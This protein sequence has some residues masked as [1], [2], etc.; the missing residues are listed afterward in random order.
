MTKAA[1]LDAAPGTLAIED[2]RVA[3]PGPN[4]VLVRTV[5]AGLC[6]SD[7]H[8]MQ[9]LYPYPLPAVL[10]HES[11]GVVEAVGTQVSDFRPGDHVV[12]CVS[13]FCGSCRYCLTGRPFLCDKVGLTR[14][15]GD[16]P[17]LARNGKPLFQ[18]FDL[19][20]FSELLLVHEHL[21]VKIRPDMPLDKAALIGC[22]VQTGVGAVINTA[23]VRPGDSVAVIGCGGIGLN[24]V[25]AAAIAGASR[26]IAVDRLA[27]KLVLAEAFGA[28]DTV[29]AS[30][31]DPVAAVQ[32]LTSGGV[33]HSFEAI[34]LKATAEQAFSMLGKGGTATVIGMVPMGQRL[35]ID[36]TALISGKRLQ[37]SN[38]GSNRFRVDMPQYVDW[39]LAGRLK[40]DELVSATMPL[41][42]INDGFATLQGGHVARQLILF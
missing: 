3:D 28:T 40:L 33:D 16:P 10:G 20:S 5:A 36:A 12:S 15:P 32:E 39:Y 8:F 27:E 30:A 35:E 19:A 6:H 11:S 38:M 1:V 13:G 2:I 31:T 14:G 37:G 26:I 29:D 4:E 9:G 23:Q 21:L 25:Q 24:A 41:D 22:G 17:R 42:R 18:F 34:G 7:L